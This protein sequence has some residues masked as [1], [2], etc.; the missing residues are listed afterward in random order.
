[1]RIAE[2]FNRLT[3]FLRPPSREFNYTYT[4]KEEFEKSIIMTLTLK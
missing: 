1:M 2:S 4:T 3:K